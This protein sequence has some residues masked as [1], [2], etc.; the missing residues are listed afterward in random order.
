M[1]CCGKAPIVKSKAPGAK[2]F[3]LMFSIDSH[4]SCNLSR[5]YFVSSAAQ[6]VI[7]VF[8]RPCL[9]SR[10]SFKVVSV[11][12]LP[13]VCL[14]VCNACIVVKRYVVKVSDGTVLYGDDELS[15]NAVN[16]RPNHVAISS[17]L[18]AVNAKLLS[19]FIVYMR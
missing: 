2:A 4:T 16:S 10:L 9:R 17:G 14:S 18:A 12:R 6:T 11:Y 3:S 8:G 15:Y 1:G 19:K 13:S 7:T 5:F